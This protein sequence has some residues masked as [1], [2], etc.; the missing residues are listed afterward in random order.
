MAEGVR[1]E[2]TRELAPPAGFQDQCLKP[3]G[4]PSAEADQALR[5]VHFKNETR[6]DPSWAQLAP[7]RFCLPPPRSLPMASAAFVSAFFV[8]PVLLPGVCFPRLLKLGT[9]FLFRLRAPSI[10]L[11]NTALRSAFSSV[12][13]VRVWFFIERQTRL[14]I[15][16]VM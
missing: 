10:S 6:F 12:G 13:A 9:H 14:K 5:K 11:L 2:L 3:L 4:H 8:Q 15:H 7:G 16:R 1:F